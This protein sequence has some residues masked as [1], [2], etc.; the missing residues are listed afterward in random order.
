MRIVWVVC[1]SLK[2]DMI[3]HLQKIAT[4]EALF[5]SDS[6][7]KR[8]RKLVRFRTVLSKFEAICNLYATT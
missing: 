1:F 6:E 7:H 4:S 8:L 5:A 2:D 3:A